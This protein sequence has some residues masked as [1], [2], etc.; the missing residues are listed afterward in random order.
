MTLDKLACIAL[1]VF[2]LGAAAAA[3]DTPAPEMATGIS[4]KEAVTAQRFMVAAANPLAAQAG[5][6][7]LAEGG[8]A[9]DAM[10]AVQFVLNLVEPQSSGI[11]G[12]AFLVAYDADSGSLRTF[13]GRETAPLAADESLFLDPAG[14]R[15]GFWDAVVGG[16][17]VGTPG[18][19]K[20]METAHRRYGRLDWARLLEPAITLAEQGFAVSPRLAAM[21]ANDRV[22]ERLRTFP[23]AREYFYPG[24]TAL[25][26]GDR[27]ANPAFAETLRTVA[28]EGA[29]A[30]YTGPIAQD[31]VAAVRGAEGNPGLLSEDDL[32]AYAV[33]ERDPVCAAYRGRRVCGM[34]PPSSGALTVGQ[35]LRL[36]EHFDMPSLGPDSPEA[37][38]LFIEASKLAYADR[39]LYM[40][41]S[42][43]V[44]VPTA[45]LL[46]DTYMTQRAQLIS[47]DAALEA[48]A[49]AGNPPWREA[50][51]YGAHDGL[52]LPGTS[53]VS[54]IDGE[55]NA[56]S[57]TTTIET[58]FG[59]TL[60][61][62]GFLLNNELTDFSFA[63]ADALGRP[64]ANRVQPG[65]RPRSSMA[66]TIVLDENGKVE[67][68]IG[69]PGGSRI[70]AYVAKTLVAVLD[71][72]MDVQS[73][74]DLP[75]IANRNG[76]TDLEAG[77]AAQALGEALAARGHETLVRDLN[78]GLHGIRVTVDGLVGGADPRREG[79]VLGD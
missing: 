32:A 39:A 18:T 20:L 12:G 23:A 47:R 44:S 1:T 70:I 74:I 5:Y 24:G 13:D 67:L 56:M 73:A 76:A 16:R 6:D 43:F 9:A 53:H 37:W 38:H 77:T 57:L 26:A 48:P 34:G 22:A 42:D 55:G 41:D 49:A 59:S 71:W 72:D 46:D 15:L 62:R 2:A 68:L 78:S 75:H 63:P 54:I 33:I 50:R 25:G 52:D 45:G 14:E 64:I 11:G 27:L 58:G 10:V 17:S 79:V 35:I 65:K 66:P 36:L 29:G 31:I 21:L 30:F 8:S 40:A 61:V 28:A 51:A 19:L 4:E 7:V 69:S 60:M 3:Q